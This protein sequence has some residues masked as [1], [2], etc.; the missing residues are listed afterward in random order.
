MKVIFDMRT[1]E[2]VKWD[3]KEHSYL[4]PELYFEIK[5]SLDKYDYHTFY[6]NAGEKTIKT[7]DDEDFAEK[8]ENLQ[9]EYTVL[10]RISWAMPKKV[11]NGGLSYFG[12]K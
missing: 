5:E 1:N 10:Y 3:E 4:A 12:L 7:I 11:Y 2:W 8:Y 6:T 9:K